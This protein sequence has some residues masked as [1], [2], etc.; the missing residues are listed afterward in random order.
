MS[1]DAIAKDG[2]F[3]YE[4]TDSIKCFKYVVKTICGT[5]Y[6]FEGDGVKFFE[7]QSQIIIRE[8]DG[9]ETIFMKRNIIYV[10]KEV[11]S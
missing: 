2:V 11:I 10:S 1:K 4:D 9:S 7:N 5:C 3:M 8:K 6:H